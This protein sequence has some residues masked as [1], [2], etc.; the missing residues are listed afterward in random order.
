MNSSFLILFAHSSSI[1]P[2]VVI[3]KFGRIDNI[4]RPLSLFKNVIFVQLSPQLEETTGCS[5]MIF[6]PW[7]VLCNSTHTIKTPIYCTRVL[8]VFIKYGFIKL[9]TI[10]KF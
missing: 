5:Y 2:S 3:F 1:T 8:L 7:S 10:Y 4:V 6:S 9:I